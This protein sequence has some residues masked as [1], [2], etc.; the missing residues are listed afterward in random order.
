MSNSRRVG[1]NKNPWRSGQISQTEPAAPVAEP[2]PATTKKVSSKKEKARAG[3]QHV[4]IST[5]I[6]DCLRGS[7]VNIGE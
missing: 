3:G 7:S 2:A 5:W 1:H 6:E 4:K